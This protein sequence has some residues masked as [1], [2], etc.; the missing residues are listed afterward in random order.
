MSHTPGP[1]QVGYGKGVTGPRAAP[2]V[3][4]DETG[5]F[6]LP[7]RAGNLPVAWILSTGSYGKEDAD[8]RLIA[9]APDLLAALHVALEAVTGDKYASRIIEAAIAKA[10]GETT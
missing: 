7:I 1:W 5:C 2:L 3:Y 6:E 9:A 10:T 8:A 4:L